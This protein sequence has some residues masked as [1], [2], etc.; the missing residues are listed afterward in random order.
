MKRFFISVWLSLVLVLTPRAAESTEAGK[1]SPSPILQAMDKLKFRVVED[2]AKSL[3]PLLLS[4]PA[5]YQL[6]VP[7]TLG[8][9]L[10]ITVNVQ[11]KTVE[12]AAQEIKTKL[13][14]DYYQDASVELALLDRAQKGGRVLIYGAVRSNLIDLPPGEQRTILE[15]V[16]Q[17]ATNEFAKLAK[18][19]LHR[20]NPATGKVETRVIDVEAIKKS[21]D[22][23][24]DV[25]LQDGDRIEIPER[26]IVF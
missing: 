15:A 8:H 3:E 17:A 24:K 2:P 9:P 26:G 4:V 25:V 7:V 1:A 13:D 11:G 18:V 6:E 16:L 21:G 20:L 23:S 22:R 10:K 12:Q 19:R 5:N 14:A